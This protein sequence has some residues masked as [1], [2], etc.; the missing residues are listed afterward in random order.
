MLNLRQHSVTKI[1]IPAMATLKQYLTTIKLLS[2]FTRS[3]LLTSR[4]RIQRHLKTTKNP[5]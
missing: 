2:P 3:I 4:P 1:P 5:E